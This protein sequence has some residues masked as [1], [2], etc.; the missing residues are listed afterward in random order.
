MPLRLRE[1]QLSMRSSRLPIYFR[2]DIACAWM[3][4]PFD[5]SPGTP[6]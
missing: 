1:R 3:C 5:A 4:V 2:Y 6:S